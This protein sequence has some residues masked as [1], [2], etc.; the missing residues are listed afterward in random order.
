[1]ELPSISTTYGVFTG[2]A[3]FYFAAAVIY[4]KLRTDKF[5]FNIAG[6]R[7]GLT[8]WP[9]FFRVTLLLATIWLLVVVVLIVFVS[10]VKRNDIIPTKPS[11]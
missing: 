1:M 8:D 2:I 7:V 4:S 11:Q 9:L 5:V 3:I 10:T 6:F